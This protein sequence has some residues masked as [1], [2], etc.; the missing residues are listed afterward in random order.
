MV[1]ALEPSAI[2]KFNPAHDAP[3]VALGQLQWIVKTAAVDRNGQIYLWDP[4]T[5]QLVTKIDS[6]ISNITAAA[7][8]PCLDVM[9]LGTS[10]GCVAIFYFQPADARLLAK[11]RLH[12]G[13]IKQAHLS[14]HLDADGRLFLILR[15]RALPVC[16]R[17]TVWS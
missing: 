8:S 16:L 2:Q 10:D 1:D 7:F 14:H 17:K 9:V 4:E 15:E 13:P 3:V 11:L 5:M 6:G 12:Q